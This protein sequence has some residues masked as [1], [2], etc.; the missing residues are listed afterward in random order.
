MV[1]RP[2][3]GCSARCAHAWLYALRQCQGAD[4]RVRAARPGPG[5]S[6]ADLYAARRARRKVSDLARRQAVSSAEYWR[7]GAEG[8]TGQGYRE[9]VPARSEF[10]AAR[11]I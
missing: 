4:E 1:D 3:G 11:R 8:G 10:R 2:F 6:G 9:A 7:V 5:P